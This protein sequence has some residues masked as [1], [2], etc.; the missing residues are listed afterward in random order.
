ML[1]T[2]MLLCPGLAGCSSSDGSTL[3]VF[4]AASL[5]GSF[6]RLADE[7]EAGNPG[8]KVLL[9]FAGSSDLAS[10]IIQGAPADVF[11]S[12][13][14]GNMAKVQ[15]AGLLDG[16]TAFATNALTIAVPPSNPASVRSF[17]DLARPGVRVVSCA[18][19]VPCGA[20]TDAIE[21]ATGITLRPVSEESAVTDV[22][23]KVTS[24]EADAGLV[25]VT[26]VRAAGGKATGIP[27][28]ESD[29]AVNTY[30][31]ATLASSRKRELAESFVA[32]VTGDDGRRILSEAGFGLPTRADVVTPATGPAA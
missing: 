8:S 12:A 21:A 9:N 15:A 7:F 5:K 2:A 19:Q 16:S 20:A 11:A 31:I 32:L 1:V 24:G 28:A 3:T 4:A 6:S 29:R 27:F 18:S 25:Y 14:A 10:Q 17:A 23:N 26:D 13:D 30:P 22:L